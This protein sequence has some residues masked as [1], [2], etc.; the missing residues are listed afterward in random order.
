MKNS[1]RSFILNSSFLIPNFL[2][3]TSRR[4]LLLLVFAAA[5]IALGVLSA[6]LFPRDA[7]EDAVPRI[8]LDSA[9]AAAWRKANPWLFRD[10]SAAAFQTFRDALLLP[11]AVDNAVG[12]RGVRRRGAFTEITFPRGR[13]IHAIAYELETRAARAGFR[14][15]EGREV[16]ALAD[17][18]EYM[19]TDASGGAYAVRLV[20]GQ[21]LAAGSFRMALVITDLGRAGAD[22][23]RAWL[24]FAAPLTLVLPDTLEVPEREEREDSG[25]ERD[26]LVELPM[27][28]VAYPVVKP[29]P[30]ALFIDDTRE[31]TEAILRARLEGQPGAAGFATKHGDRAIENPALMG[32]V[33]AFTAERDLLFLDLTGSSR[34]LAPQISLRTGAESFA[35]VA[36]S[37]ASPRGGE[38]ELERTLAAELERR[39]ALARR[40]GEGVWVLRHTPGL[41]AILARVLR[42]APGKAAEPGPRWVTLRRLHRSGD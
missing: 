27:E 8:V 41:P 29:G 4:I 34:S 10:D 39:A 7:E 15:V 5:L 33:L 19:L 2:L 6:R 1:W 16:G 28:P 17:R 18:V 3:V 37:A 30:R 9:D 12:P 20:L 25:E 26:V 21:A 22:D 38:K 40:S 13:P 42:A 11:F 32:S 14:V 24:D 31:E 23:L 36:Q 35:A